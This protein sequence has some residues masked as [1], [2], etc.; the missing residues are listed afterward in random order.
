[1]SKSMNK[2]KLI[3]VLALVMVMSVCVGMFAFAKAEPVISSVDEVTTFQMD[4]AELL[5]E[6]EGKANGIQFT[7]SISAEEFEAVKSLGEVETGLIIA[8]ADYHLE[9]AFSKDNLFGAEA[10]YDW[11]EWDNETYNYVYNGE[12]IRVININANSWVE[13]ENGYSY[14]GAIIDILDENVQEYFT[15]FAYIGV[16]GNYILTDMITTSVGIELT[17]LESVSWIPS[18]W[19]FAEKTVEEGVDLVNVEG[20]TEF[21]VA[22]YMGAIPGATFKM[23]D[24]TGKE[25]TLVDGKLDLTDG[26]NFRVWTL[27]KSVAG[28]DVQECTIDLYAGL[29]SPVWTDFADT[30]AIGAYYGNDKTKEYISVK[31]LTAEAV[32]F[33]GKQAFEITN[34][35]GHSAESPVPGELFM[36]VAPIHSKEYYAQYE[37]KDVSFNYSFYYAIDSTF[38]GNGKYVVNQ[39]S[40]YGAS[41]RTTG[42]TKGT[43]AFFNKWYNVSIPLDTILA[44][45][46]NIVNLKDTEYS[47]G[48]GMTRGMVYA[49]T[50]DFGSLGGFEGTGLKLYL[51]DFEVALD[52]SNLAM[53][54]GDIL[55]KLDDVA[56]KT[57]LDLTSY[58]KAEDVE[59]ITSVA[60]INGVTYEMK[61]Y[62]I[63]DTIAVTDLTK[64]DVSEAKEAAYVLTITSAGM[65]LYTAAIDLYTSTSPVVWAESMTAENVVLRKLAYST[66]WIKTN[67]VL[68]EAG[69][70]YEFVDTLTVG[71]KVYN[72]TYVK[73]SIKDACTIAFDLKALHT[74]T[75]YQEMSDLTKNFHIRGF[76]PS[77]ISMDA[78]YSYNNYGIHNANGTWRNSTAGN[79]YES[80]V[81]SMDNYLIAS[82]NNSASG[83]FYNWDGIYS[84]K[85]GAN[86]MVQFEIPAAKA[87]AEAPYVF[88]LG[89]V[90]I[91]Q[92]GETIA[93]APAE[94]TINLSS[95]TSYDLI[96]LIPENQQAK[97]KAM[98]KAWI[99]KSYSCCGVRIAGNGVAFVLTINGTKHVVVAAEDGSTMLKLD[100]FVVNAD[101]TVSD[102]V[103]VGDLLKEGANTVTIKGYAL[104]TTLTIGHSTPLMPESTITIVG[105]AAPVVE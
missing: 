10:V 45:W 30:S 17:K 94:T 23:I 85:T 57:A 1:M 43:D 6:G 51:A 36:N 21:D 105:P 101:G 41:G 32:E 56:D 63:A 102:S 77:S 84:D 31:T 97:Y 53:Q 20:E 11:A 80:I 99:G 67:A 35:I 66:D 33:D 25:A 86:T 9:N 42:G 82:D 69:V 87:T 90:K 39:Y 68:L 58:M 96:N 60:A 98:A 103:K 12:K 19:A 83:K 13:S 74:K 38:D 70:D 40:Y 15:G 5:I 28:F 55:V 3:M 81:I 8:P 24:A 95:A 104:P 61:G 49:L 52:I 4:G 100:D 78:N 18:N 75:Y 92:G 47:W 44:D 64:V 26:S 73:V 34:I 79:C 48:I 72:N 71:D 65:P 22:D 14:S 91:E 62:S 88:Y 46:D 50:S 2:F 27:I 76:F 37:G 7:A 54:G 89:D 16:N 93:K 59:M 29:A